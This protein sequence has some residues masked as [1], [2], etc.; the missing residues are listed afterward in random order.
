MWLMRR[1]TEAL[2]DKRVK[3]WREMELFFEMGFEEHKMRS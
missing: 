2:S 3:G 1:V